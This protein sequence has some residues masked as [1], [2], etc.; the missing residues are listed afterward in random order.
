MAELVSLHRAKKPSLLASH[1]RRIG[2]GRAGWGPTPENP[3]IISAS[4]LRDFLRCR[5]RWW[6][7]HQ[8]RLIPAGGAAPLEFGGL[9]HAILERWYMERPKKRD[10]KRM[11]EAIRFATKNV[12]LQALD[13]EDLELLRAMC[14]GYAT[15]AQD[16]DERI[17]L[18]EC[19]PEE[20]F[21]LPL[22]EEKTILVRGKIDTVFKS[23][24]LKKVMGCKEFKFKKSIDLNIVEMNLQLSVYLW[25]LSEKY[26]GMKEY[27]AH[28]TVLRK[29]MPGPRVKA[30]L[31]GSES[32]TR[33][34]QQIA[35]WKQ[36]TARAALDML[37]AAIYPN[38]MDSCSWDCDFR[39]PCM[40]R[41][42]DEDLEHVLTT[43]YKIKEKR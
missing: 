5:V 12:S 18:E 1:D 3:L 9:G 10:V 21:E 6:W 27:Q 19:S 32:V 17:G 37:D 13:T 36:D 30:D 38:P 42:E 25:A 22:D 29:Q 7:R 16:E 39:N 15:W 24:R 34:P 31:F 11:E 40:L 28:Y 4:E 23:T 26:P 43:E 20:W 8:C 33:T 14:L 2:S 41:G 35:Q